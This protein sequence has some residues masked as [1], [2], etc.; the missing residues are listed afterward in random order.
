MQYVP[1]QQ[2]I[3]D[4]LMLSPNDGKPLKYSMQVYRILQKMNR[5]GITSDQLDYWNACVDSVFEHY[6][7]HPNKPL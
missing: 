1:I 3:K 5:R 6:Q 2:I 7:G 4:E